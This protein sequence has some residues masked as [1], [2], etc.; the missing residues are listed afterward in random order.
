MRER[1]IVFTKNIELNL[2]QQKFPGES[3]IQ[4]SI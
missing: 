3:F 4:S 2:F 1:D